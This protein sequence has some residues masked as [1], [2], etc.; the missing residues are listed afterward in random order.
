MTI[1]AAVI[2]SAV[3]GGI[4]GFVIATRLW[5]WWYTDEY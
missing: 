5:E 4:I 3:G 1:V 2:S